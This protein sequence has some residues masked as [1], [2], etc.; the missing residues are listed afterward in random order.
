MLFGLVSLTVRDWLRCML[1]EST[2][3]SVLARDVTRDQQILPELSSLLST[4]DD[5]LNG[6]GFLNVFEEYP[7]SASGGVTNNF[8]SCLYTVRSTGAGSGMW[9][10]FLK[11][12][13]LCESG[14]SSTA[15]SVSACFR[16]APFLRSFL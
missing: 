16:I 8:D 5:L 10:C 9:L 4:R 13:F 7:R 2:T 6:G 14:P 12:L 11:V 3:G 15:L 1:L